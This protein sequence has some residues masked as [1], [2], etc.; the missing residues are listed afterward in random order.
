MVLGA[1]L[2]ALLL[3]LA[4]PSQATA[5]GGGD[6]TYVN[7][8]PPPTVRRGGFAMAITTGFG[9]S[10]VS[11][12]PNKVS[13]LSDP[14]AEVSQ[15]ALG[16]TFSLW[17]GGA[18]R[19]WLTFGLGVRSGTGFGSD[20]V[21]AVPAALLHVEAFPLFFK[22]GAFRDL[23]L[24]FDG[25]IGTGT[26]I[27]SHAPQNADPLASGGAMSFLGFSAFYE[28]L[29]FW[30]FSAGPALSYSHAFSQSL[31]SHQI[32]LN[33]RVA[34]YGVQPKAPKSHASMN[35]GETARN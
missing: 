24:A 12:F 34:L 6:S 9:W 33:F 29:K 32:T 26:I 15:S 11:G 7:Y 20:T 25:G 30:N 16:S 8:Q 5:P 19:D 31:S 4:N 3:S 35:A 10:G 28:P 21:S 1:G 18:I 2:S 17:L 14:N 27:D 22:G 13:S 23:G